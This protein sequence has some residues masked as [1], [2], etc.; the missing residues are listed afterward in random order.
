M[1]ESKYSTMTIDQ[2]REYMLGH[3]DEQSAFFA[4][5][6]RLRQMPMKTIPAEVTG[7]ELTQAIAE[8]VRNHDARNRHGEP[9]E[10]F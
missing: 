2:L 3:R 5:M 6:D 10:Q 1:N 4:Y 9:G 7:E 8:I